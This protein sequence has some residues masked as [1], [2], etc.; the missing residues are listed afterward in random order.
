MPPP[1]MADKLRK[2]PFAL[3][4][5]EAIEQLSRFPAWKLHPLKGGLQG[6]LEP[7]CHRKPALDSPL[8]RTDEHCRRY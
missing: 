7:D 8:R 1:A 5:A 6:V 4:T 2:L 3:E